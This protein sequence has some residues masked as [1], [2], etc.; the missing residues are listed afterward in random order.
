MNNVLH[1]ELDDFRRTENNMIIQGSSHTSRIL[2]HKY[3]NKAIINTYSHLAKLD[4]YYDSIACCGASGMMVVPQVADLLKKN[5]ILVRKNEN[6]YSDFI[7]EGC[8]PK[9]YIIVDDL[10]CSGNTIK[11]ILNHIKA[12]TPRAK[13]VGVYCYM[14]DECAYNTAPE[15]CK[16]DLGINYLNILK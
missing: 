8:S 4:L 9:C 15:Y 7:V 16:R 12:E 3:R 5:V 6:R 10:I 11:Y 2:N 1:Q 14:P 13:C